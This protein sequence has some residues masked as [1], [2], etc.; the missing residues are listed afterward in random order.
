MKFTM[1]VSE[2]TL[3]TIVTAL[4][5]ERARAIDEDNAKNITIIENALDDIN[6]N[7]YVSNVRDVM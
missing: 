6:K 5:I 1:T 4:K 3:N 2:D 7:T